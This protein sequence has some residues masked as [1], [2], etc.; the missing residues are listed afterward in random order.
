MNLY[1]TQ[2]SFILTKPPKNQFRMLS[3]SGSALEL[4]KPCEKNETQLFFG[5]SGRELV[6]KLLHIWK[7]NKQ[8]LS[9]QMEIF[10]FLHDV[11]KYEVRRLRKCFA[12]IKPWGVLSRNLHSCSLLLQLLLNYFNF[13]LI[14]CTMLT[15]GC[16]RW[17]RTFSGFIKD[18]ATH[19]EGNNLL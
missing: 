14:F 5:N 18:A 16:I 8:N 1:R 15:V 19:S 11:R 9:E 2:N 4:V 13:S 6:Y 10:K 3:G 12:D 7:M 17:F